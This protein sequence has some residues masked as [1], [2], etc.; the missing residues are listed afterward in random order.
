M[1][2]KE[3]RLDTPDWELRW[4]RPSG[5]QEELLKTSALAA[6]VL[7]ESKCPGHSTTRN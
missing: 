6:E 1:P 5:L 3:R 4:S 7:W 2:Y